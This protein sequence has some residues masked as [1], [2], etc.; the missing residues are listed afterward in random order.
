MIVGRSLFF[1]FTITTDTSPAQMGCSRSVL[2]FGSFSH[3]QN[4]IGINPLYY[5]RQCVRKA[6]RDSAL[7]LQNTTINRLFDRFGNSFLISGMWVPFKCWFYVDFI[8]VDFYQHVCHM[9]IVHH[10]SAVINQM[11]YSNAVPVKYE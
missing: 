10:V 3:F 4:V 5:E 6:I 8:Y 1:K 2:K 9:L 11:F 7:I